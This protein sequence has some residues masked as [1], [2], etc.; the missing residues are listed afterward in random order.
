MSGNLNR[1]QLLKL[2]GM[3]ALGTSLSNCVTSSAAATTANWGYI[4]KQGPEYWGKLSSDFQLCYTGKRQTP[5][6][7]EFASVKNADKNQDL[8]AINYQP[9]PLNV[10][11]NGKT[12]QVKYQPGSFIE[13]NRQIFNLLQFHFH[14]PSE[15]RING[16]L[17]DMELHF[18][19]RH[20]TG[21]LAVI[22][23]FLKAGK[24][25]PNLQTIW[26]TMPEKQG[27]ENTEAGVVINA[28]QLLPAEHRFLTYSGSLTTPPCSE[29][30]T[31]YVME[32]PIEVSYEQ[33]AKFAQLFP[34][35]T[36]PIQPLN[37]RI[38][39]E[40]TNTV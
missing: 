20:Q 6:D 39:L 3:S 14:H 9:S 24:F 10:I 28:S 22:G 25:N 34:H 12:I 38:V 35:N 23:V 26:D 32:N 29:N 18:V 40:S 2:L 21:N 1:R 37:E 27:E 7:L 16:E 33:I 31:W 17:Y 5:I 15:H 36:R 4:G 30:V 19:H 11:N 13:C 8:L